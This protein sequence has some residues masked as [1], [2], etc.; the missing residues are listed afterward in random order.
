MENLDSILGVVQVACGVDLFTLSGIDFTVA[1]LAIC[2]FLVVRSERNSCH[3]RNYLRCKHNFLV[4]LLFV[5]GNRKQYNLLNENIGTF[6]ATY[7]K[8]QE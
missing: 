2:D 4:V 1:T 6:K 3:P 7:N 5:F 8:H